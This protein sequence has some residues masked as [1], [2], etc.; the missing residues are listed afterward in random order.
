[1]KELLEC[2]YQHLPARLITRVCEQAT[3]E[4]FDVLYCDR[5]GHTN[6]CG[7]FNHSGTD[8]CAPHF[9]TSHQVR[10]PGS[11]TFHMLFHVFDLI[12]E[13]YCGAAGIVKAYET[14]CPSG[15]P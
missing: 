4:R 14:S 7:G 10:L 3:R 9:S 5:C 13:H 11:G 2:V 6:L 12:Y 15:V 1:M 8:L